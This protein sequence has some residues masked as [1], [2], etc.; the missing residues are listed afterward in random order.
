MTLT[1]NKHPK[2]KYGQI[3]TNNYPDHVYQY[4]QVI[5]TVVTR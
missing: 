2:T 3:T 4:H 5:Y 1:R